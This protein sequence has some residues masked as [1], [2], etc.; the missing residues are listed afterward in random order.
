MSP[1]RLIE[2]LG[3]LASVVLPFFNIPLI[4]R[5]IRRRSS[6]DFSLFWAIGVWIC[7]VLMMPQA[8]LSVDLAFKVFGI[9]NFV[10]FTAVVFFILKYRKG[11][12][13]E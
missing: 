1:E 12:P 11:H 3:I 6:K 9:V 4:L 7:V 10:F 5:V 13:S 2:I 8:L